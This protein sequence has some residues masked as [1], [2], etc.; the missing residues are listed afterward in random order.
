[1]ASHRGKRDRYASAARVR[2][3]EPVAP[4]HFILERGI[5]VAP[6][7]SI[8][9]RKYVRLDLVGV[10]EGIGGVEQAGDGEDFAE[11]FG[12]HAEF[13]EGGGMGIDAVGAAVGSG[14][15]QRDGLARSGIEPY[16]AAGGFV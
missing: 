8:D 14:D 9:G 5:H 12:V 13:A 10:G 15:G 11:G 1:M 2:S 6:N 7:G 3:T 16:L 4:A